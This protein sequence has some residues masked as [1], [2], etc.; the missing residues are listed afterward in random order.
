[1]GVSGA[2]AIAGIA[3]A[4]V[5]GVCCLACFCFFLREKRQQNCRVSGKKTGPSSTEGLV[6]PGEANYDEAM[7]KLWGGP[8]PKVFPT[9]WDEWPG[10]Y[11]SGKG[12]TALVT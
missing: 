11:P 8:S 7:R 5:V 3:V 2:A 1:M 9:A 12:K 6:N 10:K 4:S